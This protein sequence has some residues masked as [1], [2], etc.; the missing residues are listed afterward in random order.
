MQ[1]TGFDLLAHHS[2]QDGL[3]RT[4]KVITAGYFGKKEDGSLRVYFTRYYEALLFAKGW[5]KRIQ[6]SQDNGGTE[7][8]KGII[9][10][11]E[12]KR[13]YKKR[14][15]SVSIYQKTLDFE[16]G[17]DQILVFFHGNLYCYLQHG[18]VFLTVSEIHKTKST[19]ERLNRILMRF[20][21]CQLY[22]KNKVWF[23]Y[24]PQVG[25]AEYKY[26]T[27]IPYLPKTFEG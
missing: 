27:A 24:N 20:C 8:V 10:A 2:R 14:N 21:G 9:R 5:R 13:D 22:Q 18:K 23:I 26:G 11:I 16:G 15:D 3:T 17:D 19:K 25:D 1:L 6:L 7:T 4:E 12:E